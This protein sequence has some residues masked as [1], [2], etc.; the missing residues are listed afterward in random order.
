[1][2][3][4]TLSQVQAWLQ[5]NKYDLQVSDVDAEQEQ[6]AAD[7]VLSALTVRY[8]TDTWV[9]SSTTPGMVL[10][11]I[12]MLTASYTLRKAISEDD[13]IALYADWLE[14]RVQM[15]ID[16]I[17]SGAIDIPGVDPDP[18]APA[19]SSIGFFPTDAATQLWED[20]PTAEGGAARWFN[21]QMVF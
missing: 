7:V 20:D 11:M 4:V 21:Y 8:D 10:R 19:S 16:G 1:V 18:N 17:V 5:I 12:A 15:L 14:R 3:Y 13:G 2:S 9:D 6:L